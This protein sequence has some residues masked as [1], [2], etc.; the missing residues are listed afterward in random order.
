MGQKATG[1]LPQRRLGAC[2]G[3]EMNAL[4]PLLPQKND[5]YRIVT[6]APDILLAKAAIL[7]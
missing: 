1:S 3:C 6:A 5:F 7:T 4:Y 2:M